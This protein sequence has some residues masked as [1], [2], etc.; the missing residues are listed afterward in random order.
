M[1]RRG[2]FPAGRVEGSGVWRW[3]TL[4]GRLRRCPART[5]RLPEELLLLFG[6]EDFVHRSGPVSL[7]VERDVGESETLQT[8]NDPGSD[9]VVEKPV[10]FLWSD[11]DAGGLW[12]VETDPEEAKPFVAEQRLSAVH[13]REVFGS[14]ARAVRETG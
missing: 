12:I 5:N 7:E 4:L 9:R 8:L 1:T 3:E 2:S 11:L 6:R 14:D 10:Q 13:P